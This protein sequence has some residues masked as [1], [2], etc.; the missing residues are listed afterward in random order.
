M[1]TSTS[2]SAYLSQRSGALPGGRDGSFTVDDFKETAKV[3]LHQDAAGNTFL[4]QYVVIKDLGHGA[5][6]KVKLCLNTHT[7]RLCAIK[8]INRKLLQRHK[9]AAQGR[10]KGRDVVKKEIAIMKK[11]VHDNVVRLHEVI[12]DEVGHYIF[13]VLEYIPGGPIYVPAVYSNNGMGEELA[14]HYFCETCIGLDYLHL[15][16]VIHRDLKPENLLKKA[17]GT[18][19]ICDFGVSELFS[20]EDAAA[21]DAAEVTAAVGTPAF[22]AP[23]IAQGGRARGKPSDIWSL[24]VC[25]YYIVCGAVPFPGS[26]VL[27][28]TARI[29]SDEVLIPPSIT[30]SLG[31]LLKGILDKNPATR[32]TLEQIMRHE[33]VT[34]G[35]T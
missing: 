9:F 3:D 33:W 13:M 17:D 1:P 31:S 5:F 4:N 27:E 10:D 18:V 11:L 19:K 16:N 34:K 23:E 12:D 35:C 25:L 6:G 7:S 8:C 32:M 24:G 21:G 29:M 15:N 22:L 28:V 30:P 14:H 2:A 26:T 20:D